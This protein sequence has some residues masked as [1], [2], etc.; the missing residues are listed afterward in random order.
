MTVAG[1]RKKLGKT[2]Y[3]PVPFRNTGLAN[4]NK[5]GGGEPNGRSQ[6]NRENL[7]NSNFEPGKTENLE[8]H[9]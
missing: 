9:P 2:R 7:E 4:K 3:H 1:G 6:E 5:R 8:R